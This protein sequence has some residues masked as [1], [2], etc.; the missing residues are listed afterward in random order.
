MD[1]PSSPLVIDV[2]IALVWRDGR[3]LLTRRPEGAHLSGYWE[4]PGG[5]CLPGESPESCAERE[6]L[7][8]IGVRCR[9]VR[10][11]TEI[12]HAYPERTVRLFPI[13]CNYLG[14]NPQ[15]LEVAEWTWAEPARLSDYAF[16]P[17]NATLLEDLARESA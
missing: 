16:P 2:A 6:V 5:K 3:L 12:V 15:P 11:R 1:N 17:A 13:E 4:F 9:A 8:E 10:R 7:E 14:G